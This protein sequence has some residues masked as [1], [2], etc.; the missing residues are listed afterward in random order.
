[1]RINKVYN[2]KRISVS[3]ESSH[4]SKRNAGAADRPRPDILSEQLLL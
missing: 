4:V 3:V 1:M 2:I